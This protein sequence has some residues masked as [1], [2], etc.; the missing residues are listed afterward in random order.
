MADKF[1]TDT[2]PTPA[3]PG[4]VW[5]CP[6]GAKMPTEAT[7]PLNHV[8]DPGAAFSGGPESSDGTFKGSKSNPG[9]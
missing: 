5:Y 2:T 7:G 9:L 1:T 3:G 6:D 4:V 8:A